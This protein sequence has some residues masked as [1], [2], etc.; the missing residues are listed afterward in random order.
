MA[1]QQRIIDFR[2]RPNTATYME[3]GAIG[4]DEEIKWRRWGYP[5][6]PTVPLAE[7]VRG[8]DAAGISIAVFTGRDILRGEVRNGFSNSYLAQ[9]MREFPGRII[10]FA[11][12]D[13]QL[14]QAGADELRRAVREDGARGASL[15]PRM[16]GVHMDDR[17]A[18]PIYEAAQELGVP[19]VFT[20]GPFVGRYSDPFR[21]DVPTLDFPRLDFVC[22]HAPWPQVN[23]FLALAYRRTNVYL[24]PS[25][26]WSLPGN[27]ALFESANGWLSDRV[28]YASGHPFNPLHVVEKFKKR[29]AWSDEAWERVSWGNGARL[30]RLE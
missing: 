18:Y 21:L 15:D 22:S 9:C 8:M 27:D 29:I 12:I 16:S 19:V 11:G 20:M 5:K 17:K 23:E 7:F 13:M 26:Y 25:L 14:G 3:S 30:L 4:H 2:A 6:P 10:G 1:S 24:E 28:L